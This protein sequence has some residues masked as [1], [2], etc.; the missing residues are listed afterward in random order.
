[1]CHGPSLGPAL[2]VI[3]MLVAGLSPPASTSEGA[4]PPAM[5]S[6]DKARLMAHGKVRLHMDRAVLRLLAHQSPYTSTEYLQMRG[7]PVTIWY[8]NSDGFTSDTTDAPPYTHP[9]TAPPAGT[10]QALGGSSVSQVHVKRRGHTWMHCNMSNMRI[11]S[12]MSHENVF[13]CEA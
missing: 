5:M 9:T 13:S 1:M 11:C 8:Q 10:S 3:S 7:Q 6:W 12:L 2:N 4:Q